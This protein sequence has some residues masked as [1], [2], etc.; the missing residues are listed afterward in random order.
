MNKQDYLAI[1]ERR[2]QERIERGEF[3]ELTMP[4][5]AVWKYLPVNVQQYAISGRMP[6]HLLAKL[7]SV[8]NAPEKKL[9]QDELVELGLSAMEVTRDVMLNNLFEPRITLEE[10]GDSLTPEMIDPEDFKFF[11]NFIM[12]GAQADANSKSSKTPQK[13]KRA[14]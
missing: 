5:G 9:S 14:A 1:A 2:K 7:E 3:L 8:K 12:R 11:M 4:S 13:R 6:M 10:T